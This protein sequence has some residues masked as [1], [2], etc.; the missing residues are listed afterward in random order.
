MGQT[1]TTGAALAVGILLAAVLWAAPPDEPPP[2][3][4]P[5]PVERT[6]ADD[7]SLPAGLRCLLAA[8]PE[9]LCGATPTTLRWCD[10]TEMPWDDG[11]EKDHEGRLTDADLEDMMATPYPLGRDYPIPPRNADPGRVRHEPF[12]R[13]M[14]GD[15]RRAVGKTVAVVRWLG[16]K[17]LRVTTINGVDRALRAVSEEVERLPA[18]IRRPVTESAGTFVWRKV[19]GTDR[20]SAH[21]FAIAIDVGVSYSDFWRWTKPDADGRYRYRNRIP[22][23][24]VEIFERHGF[25]WGGK[26][27]HFDTMHFEYRPELLDSACAAPQ[28]NP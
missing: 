20:L 15:S 27:Y 14:Y 7:P 22:L 12:F 23:E 5:P 6:P 4:A 3:A 28:A 13:K 18:A 16:R 2:A 8:Y 21:S 19:R 17:K 9:Q 10:G 11:R 24:V 26:W 1:L 25:I